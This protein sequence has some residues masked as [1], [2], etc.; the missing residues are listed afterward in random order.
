ME[1]IPR[2]NGNTFIIYSCSKQSPKVKLS[3]AFAAITGID[4][5]SGQL[6]T[7]KVS[8]FWQN[9]GWRVSCKKTSVWGQYSFTVTVKS[10]GS[11]NRKAAT[12]TFTLEVFLQ[13][14]DESFDS[15]YFPCRVGD[16]F[17]STLNQD[18]VGEL[19][20]CGIKG[21]LF[22]VDRNDS[23]V[24][25]GSGLYLSVRNLGDL[26]EVRI[27]GV[28]SR[29]GIYVAAMYCATDDYYSPD[30]RDYF[31]GGNDLLAPIIVA[32]RDK[33]YEENQLM[34]V[35]SNQASH[36]ENCIRLIFCKK[37]PFTQNGGRF[38]ITMNGGGGVWRGRYE[39]Q[40]QAKIIITEFKIELNGEMWELAHR[41]YM[42]EDP[43]PDWNTISTAKKIFGSNI[44]PSAGWSDGV[45]IAGDAYYFVPGYGLFDYKG[46]IDERP[47]Y[48]QQ[49]LH[50]RQYEG[51]KRNK[52]YMYDAGIILKEKLINDTWQWCLFSSNNTDNTL[53]E[54]V[55]PQTIQG[56]IVPYTPPTTEKYS[57]N[58]VRD[59]TFNNINIH[60]SIGE[61]ALFSG[62][63]AGGFW[64]WAD[65]RC[66]LVPYNGTN[67]DKEYYM[68]GIT[69][70][71]EKYS[72][73][74]YGNKHENTY[75]E[76][77]GIYGKN[78][79]AGE[80]KQGVKMTWDVDR[81][82]LKYCRRDGNAF[83]WLMTAVEAP[84]AKWEHTW[85]GKDSGYSIDGAYPEKG[86]E[87]YIYTDITISTEYIKDDGILTKQERPTVFTF[88][89]GGGADYET[90]KWHNIWNVF[91][92]MGGGVNGQFNDVKK[93]Y[94]TYK[95]IE[96]STEGYTDVLESTHPVNVGFSPNFVSL[97]PTLVKIGED[98]SV[99]TQT[100]ITEK[101]TF[102]A[103]VSKIKQT[104]VY[105]EQQG[106]Y[107]TTKTDV[108]KEYKLKIV[109]DRIYTI[110]NG[111]EITSDL[112]ATETLTETP[113]GTYTGSNIPSQTTQIK[114]NAENIPDFNNRIQAVKDDVASCEL[115]STTSDHEWASGF[116]RWEGEKSE[117]KIEDK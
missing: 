17:E 34:V 31:S 12:S 20:S 74:E 107:V 101:S 46:K 4:S 114:Y 63:Y 83:S 7:E 90:G 29:P 55:K 10:K 24:H 103:E 117:F 68:K 23:D 98:L 116:W 104:V 54:D 28:A 56:A 9:G 112:T 15:F 66:L 110:I 51:W 93:T 42:E 61:I 45:V 5:V 79:K 13:A 92:W 60:T 85:E 95:A 62:G 97:E 72:F 53:I 3:P 77:E 52:E 22:A 43:P 58:A 65:E 14:V 18:V 84:D 6:D 30:G 64:N 33:N 76:G 26:D 21:Q 88:Y 99:G 115:A 50:T 27:T 94:Y 25:Y 1:D 19:L 37:H 111:K 8:I 69:A 100:Q 11:E 71:V 87:P 67:G 73:Y 48:Q 39:E 32:V 59:L 44:P 106:E 16:K 109:I 113:P 70:T 35:T 105:D 2:S 40:S 80:G 38:S 108:R 89:V 81:Q 102:T 41:E 57:Q 49:P 78:E 86:K 82:K 75:I 96:G 91:K 36:N 47:F